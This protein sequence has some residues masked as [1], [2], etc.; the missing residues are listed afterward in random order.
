MKIAL[1]YDG[2]VTEDSELWA[3]FVI[4][5]VRKGHEVRVVTFRKHEDLT[6]DMQWFAEAA[7]DIPLVFTGRVPKKDYCASIGWEP[8]IWIDDNPELILHPT[9]W[10]E[11]DY[12]EWQDS[13]EG[14]VLYAL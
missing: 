8:D 2:T 14:K 4:N 11:E 6:R 10:S 13:L 3:S 12:K 7:G 9:E 5:A 1:D